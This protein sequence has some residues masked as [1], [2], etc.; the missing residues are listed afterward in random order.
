[1]KMS[2][3]SKTKKLNEVDLEYINTSRESFRKY[4]LP[5]TSLDTMIKVQNLNIIVEFFIKFEKQAPVMISQTAQTFKEAVALATE[6][7]QK[8]L[9]RIHDKKQNVR[10]KKNLRKSSITEE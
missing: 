7:M 10:H 9:R 1:M 6:R 3:T 4:N 8:A 2:I 5:I